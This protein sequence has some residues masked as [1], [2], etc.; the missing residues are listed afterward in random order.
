MF[1]CETNKKEGI[2]AK[3]FHGY[4]YVFTVAICTYVWWTLVSKESRHSYV[5]QL[6][7]LLSDFFFLHFSYAANFT[8]RF[9]KKK[10]LARSINFRYHYVLSLNESCGDNVGR[11]YPI[12]HKDNLRN[13]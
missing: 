7:P 11:T 3:L 12:E 1:N 5:W 8:Q 10:K 9:L 13:S 6:C 2:F 4:Q